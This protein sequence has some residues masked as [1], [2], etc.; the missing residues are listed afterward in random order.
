VLFLPVA[1]EA[2]RGDHD[3]KR[4]CPRKCGLKNNGNKRG[5]CVLGGPQISAPHSSG[6]PRFCCQRICPI[7]APPVCVEAG[8]FEG[9]ILLTKNVP[10]PIL[11]CTKRVLGGSRDRRTGLDFNSTVLRL[12]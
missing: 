12:I 11:Y 7:P 9:D 2:F 8:F 6:Q 4:C 3:L 5:Q 10:N 1:V